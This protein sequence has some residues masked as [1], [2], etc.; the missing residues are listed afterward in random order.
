M[1]Y[2][3]FILYYVSGLPYFFNLFFFVSLISFSVDSEELIFILKE[4]EGYCHD[5]EDEESTL[6]SIE[7]DSQNLVKK[8]SVENDKEGNSRSN[9]TPELNMGKHLKTENG[10]EL[11]FEP[12]TVRFRGKS[13]QN[14]FDSIHE[15]CDTKDD[16]VDPLFTSDTHETLLVSNGDKMYSKDYVPNTPNN[17]KFIRVKKRNLKDTKIISNP[18]EE[19]YDGFF[20][21]N[22]NETRNDHIVYDDYVE[23]HGDE[24]EFI[25]NN[26]QESFV[27]PSDSDSNWYWENEDDVNHLIDSFDKDYCLQGFELNKLYYPDRTSKPTSVNYDL[28]DSYKVIDVKNPPRRLSI[29]SCLKKKKQPKAVHEHVLSV[30]IL[31]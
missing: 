18:L 24:K 7:T 11:N 12:N 30:R 9:A 19:S 29:S 20:D 21:R 5:K 2:L 4:I 1:I 6:L 3:I 25:K 17:V 22:M 23:I 8:D 10:E 13:S 16:S 14:N 15:D 26:D 28:L 31:I 27:D